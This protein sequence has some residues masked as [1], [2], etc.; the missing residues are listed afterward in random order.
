MSVLLVTTG[1]EHAGHP[2]LSSD[3]PSLFSFPHLPLPL[4]R[5]L[6]PIMSQRC[7]LLSGLANPPQALPYLL[8]D[9]FPHHT[10]TPTSITIRLTLPS[11]ITRHLQLQLYFLHCTYLH[12]CLIIFVYYLSSAFQ[13]KFL[14]KRALSF[15]SIVSSLY[16]KAHILGAQ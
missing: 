10:T 7:L 3:M 12:L 8:G 1:S 9:A 11:P 13:Y 16:L 5:S 14:E 6:C 2:S 4:A 15:V